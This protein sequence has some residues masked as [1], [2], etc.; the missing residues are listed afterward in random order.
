MEGKTVKKFK[1]ITRRSSIYMIFDKTNSI[2]KQRQLKLRKER[3]ETLPTTNNKILDESLY[4]SNKNSIKESDKS[5]N[6]ISESVNSSI[7]NNKDN[8][9]Y[10]FNNHI[11]KENKIS[12]QTNSEELINEMKNM[13]IKNNYYKKFVSENNFGEKYCKHNPAYEDYSK[14]TREENFIKIGLNN[15]EKNPFNLIDK[16]EKRNYSNKNDNLNMKLYNSYSK[17]DNYNYLL[18]RSKKYKNNKSFSKEKN[19]TDLKK[20]KI[21]N[22]KSLSYKTF[23]TSSFIKKNEFSNYLIIE[24]IKKN[25]PSIIMN[26]ENIFNSYKEK[27]LL[28]QFCGKGI[29]ARKIYVIKDSTVISNPRLIPGFLV[30]I[31][32][33]NGIKLLKK[34]EKFNIFKNFLEFIT[35]KF[36]S[37]LAFNFIFDKNGNLI[38]DFGQIPENDKHIFVSPI[39][40]F[41]GIS[42][43]MHKGIIELYLRNFGNNTENEYFFNESSLDESL[44]NIQNNKIKYLNNNDKKDDVYDIFFSENNKKKYFKKRKIKKK[45]KNSFTFGIDDNTKYDYSF[46]YFSD[47]EKKREEMFKSISKRCK[48]RIDFYLDIKN[49]LYDKKLKDLELKLS[50]NKQKNLIKNKNSKKENIL[51]NEEELRKEFL[52]EKKIKVKYP[53]ML[54]N[55]EDNRP[56]K[57][58]DIIDTFMLLKSYKLSMDINKFYKRKKGYKNNIFIE[59]N[60]KEIIDKYYFSRKKTN[61][62]YPPLI[63]YNIPK[64]L[65][66]HPK[67]LLNDLIKYYTKFKSLINLWLNVHNNLSNAQFGIDFETFY[68]CTE[69]LCNEEKDLVKRIYEKINNSPSGFLSLEDFI[70]AL[71]SMN[72]KDLI[73]QFYFFLKIFGNIGK[74]HLSYNEVLQISIISIKRLAK[75]QKSKEDE[76]IIR[77]LGNFFANFLFKI[78]E[79]KTEDGIK[80][81]KLKEMLNSQGEKLEYLKLFL[82]FDDD[83]H[84]DRI[85]KTLK[86]FKK[87]N[88]IE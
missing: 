57:C 9:I 87:K 28:L 18:F 33:I 10:I 53:N 50:F 76:K 86:E 17:Y 16:K 43:S 45:K 74:K 25:Y 49:S 62:E 15:E 36:R 8:K 21:N 4:S 11:Y 39:N 46:I 22:I 72:Q 52:S 23:Q 27:N 88:F 65:K 83:N 32:T 54:N 30:E 38:L 73:N 1:D 77:D 68:N 6:N 69:E 71:N 84:R 82:L 55:E 42:F 66:E 51:M 2:Q 61:I 31:P 26:K 13:N 34:K 70:E 75:N 81:E 24:F 63:N 35:I 85:I 60:K 40:I 20:N 12:V 48:N 80:I 59:K 67:Y 47:N 79:A 5:N 7:N 58:Q 44:N 3:L 56:L 64:I 29:E 41:Q 14:I 78:C 19:F 37:Q